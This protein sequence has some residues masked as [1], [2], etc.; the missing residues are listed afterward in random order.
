[1]IYSFIVVVSYE[2]NNLFIEKKNTYEE[3]IICLEVVGFLT[4]SKSIDI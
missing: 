1:M 4:S 2:G 3:K